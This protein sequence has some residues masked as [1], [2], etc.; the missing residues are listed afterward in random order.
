MQRDQCAV[1]LMRQNNSA[2]FIGEYFLNTLPDLI[3]ADSDPISFSPHKTSALQSQG[4]LASVLPANEMPTRLV[5]HESS[6]DAE[7]PAASEA[8]DK[9]HLS[10]KL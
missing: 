10:R 6:A 8:H 1:E 2:Q 4:Q 9:P 5:D 3:M 7:T